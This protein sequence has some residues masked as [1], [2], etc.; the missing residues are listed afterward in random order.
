MGILELTYFMNEFIICRLRRRSQK[1]YVPLK[2]ELMFKNRFIPELMRIRLKNLSK[3]I[4][5]KIR[6]NLKL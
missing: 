4:K 6:I 3:I 2:N 5:N 1:L